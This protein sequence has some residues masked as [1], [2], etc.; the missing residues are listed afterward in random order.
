MFPVLLIPL[1]A[2]VFSSPLT[3]QASTIA[4]AA[5][6]TSVGV[7]FYSQFR[8]I[9]SSKWQKVGCGIASLAMVVDYYST[10]SPS[11]DTLLSQGIKLGAYSSNG[12][13]YDG[14]IAV[15]KK[16][17]LNGQSRILYGENSGAAFDQLAADVKHGPVIASVHYKFDPKNPI[18]HLVV[19]DRIENGFIYYNDP[20]ATAGY[21]KIPIKSFT[22]AWKKRY[23]VI[24]PPDALAAL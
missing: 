19:V 6:T 23:L 21:K 18:P 20:A 4:L 17:G 5:A 11:V 15:A 12:W 10:S 24:R 3:A 8:D 9:A 22:S 7:P 14:L 2:G 16:Y 13:T 1:L